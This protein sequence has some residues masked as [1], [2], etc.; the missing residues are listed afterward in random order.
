MTVKGS[1]KIGVERNIKKLR[2]EKK[3]NRIGSAKG[4]YWKIIE[5]K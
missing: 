4:G 2:E 3:L 5:K 1:V